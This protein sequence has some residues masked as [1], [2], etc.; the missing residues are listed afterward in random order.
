MIS[1]NDQLLRAVRLYEQG[2]ILEA[3]RIARPL[4]QYAPD[5]IQLLTLL[6]TTAQHRGDLDQASGYW[7]RVVQAAGATATHWNS[8]GLCHISAGRIREASQAFEQAIRIDANFADAYNNLGLTM[9]D[10]GEREAAGRCLEEAIR[11]NP[12]FTA[13]YCN[14]GHHYRRLCRYDAAAQCFNKALECDSYSADAA[15]GLGMVLHEQGDIVRASHY[16]REALRVRPTYSDASNNLAT[17]LKEQGQLDAAVAQY[18][19]TLALVP[20]HA[21]TIYNLSQFAAEGR[22]KFEPKELAHLKQVIAAEQG[23][24]LERSLICFAIAAVHDAER[25]HDEAFKYYR[26]AN[27][28]RK[29]ATP[30]G[31]G[32]D[33]SRHR[34]LIDRIIKIF[35]GDYFRDTRGWGTPSETPIFIVG[36]PRTGSTLVE[37]ILATDPTVFAAGELGEMPRMMQRLCHEQGEPDLYHSK[38]PFPSAES[39]QEFTRHYLA[40]LDNL[41]RRSPRVTIKTL[42]N[43]LHLGTIATI[44]PGSRII[45]CVR[46]PL[47]VCV[48]CYFQNFES[49]DFSWDLEDIA[50]YWKDH[51]RLNAH[52]Q[53]KLPLRIQEIRYEDLIRNPDKVTKELFSFCGLEWDAK[54]LRFFENRG[55][56]RTASTVQVRKPLSTKPIG[57]WQ[58]YRSHLGPLLSALGHPQSEQ[59]AE[60][61]APMPPAQP[62]PYVEPGSSW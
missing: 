24:N 51:D 27:E 21:Y 2:Q 36:L 4:L 17:A 5:H 32:F 25:S 55:A 9:Q 48:S 33:A 46:D 60:A 44:L 1:V 23:S 42:E 16:Y 29:Q 47:D 43:F 40:F 22:Y 59:A 8:L 31:A 20:H 49:L 54:C 58:R 39:A 61:P 18:R 26:K 6:A 45:H 52:W 3:E 14:L 37:Q 11:V 50:S 57:R 19:E 12:R 41:S 13:A 35:D 34:A 7:M 30:R 56:V 62:A 15:N 10:L 38:R 28:L 53:K